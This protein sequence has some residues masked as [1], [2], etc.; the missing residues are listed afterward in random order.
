MPD[1]FFD[2][3]Q[4]DKS[5][6]TPSHPKILIILQLLSKVILN[7]FQLSKKRLNIEYVKIFNL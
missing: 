3:I 7:M 5:P 2:A 6:S 1:D 4:S